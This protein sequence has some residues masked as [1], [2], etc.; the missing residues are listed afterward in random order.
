MLMEAAVRVAAATE[1]WATAAGGLAAEGRVVAGWVAAG[2]A[3]GA[4]V[5]VVRAWLGLG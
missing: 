5:R 1:G 2:S 4:A 3:T